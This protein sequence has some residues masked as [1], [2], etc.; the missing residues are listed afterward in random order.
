[1]SEAVG[2]LTLFVHIAEI[3]IAAAV[4]TVLLRRFKQPTL[5]TYII[6]GI[7]V[8]PLILGS[9]SLNLFGGTYVL[10]IPQIT[11]EIVLLSTLGTAFLLFSIGI[12]T[13]IQRLLSIGK[14]ILFGTILQV[15]LVIAVTF[16]LTVPFG[17]LN[18]QQAL[19]VGV[20]VAFSSTMIVVKLLTDRN[21]INTLNGR[22]MV[23]ILLLQDFLVVFFYPLLSNITGITSPWF[24]G[25]IILKSLLL[26]GIAFFANKY[27]FPKLFE[28]ASEEQELFFIVSIATAF[29]FIGLSRLLGIPEPIGAFIGGLSL[30]TLAYNSEIF[31]RVRALRDFFLTIF[32]VS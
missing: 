19:F 31:S 20:I 21:E 11:N 8:G 2:A 6:A 22:I 16:L 13:S 24:F 4:I 23:S 7:I 15:F 5:F 3:V 9:I 26:I 12:E 30:S 17:L 18:S 27:I 28:I 25:V 1:M 10:G 29:V 32:F 14:P